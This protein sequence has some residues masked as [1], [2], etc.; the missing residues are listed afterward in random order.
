MGLIVAATYIVSS[1]II[2][3]IKKPRFK[4]GVFYWISTS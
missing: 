2:A 4:G 3:D 1:Y